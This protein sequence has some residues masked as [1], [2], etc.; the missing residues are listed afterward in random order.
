MASFEFTKPTCI[1]KW[2]T[3]FGKSFVCN[4]SGGSFPGKSL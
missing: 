4:N 3:F 2:E 1:V